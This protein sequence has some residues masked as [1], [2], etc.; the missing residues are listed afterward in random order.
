MG[1]E[2]R[3]AAHAAWTVYLARHRDVDAQDGRRCMLER[4][5][6][7]RSEARHTN[8]EELTCSGLAYLERFPKDEW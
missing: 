8:A 1:D 6:Q 7:G 3:K 2:V 4:H 5:L